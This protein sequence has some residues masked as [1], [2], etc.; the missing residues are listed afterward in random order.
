MTIYDQSRLGSDWV[1]ISMVL[2][3]TMFLR[4]VHVDYFSTNRLN[5]WLSPD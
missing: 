2:L 3:V 1:L 4:Y 5:A